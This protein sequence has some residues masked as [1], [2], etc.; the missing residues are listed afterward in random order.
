MSADRDQAEFLGK[1][2]GLGIRLL[3]LAVPVVVFFLALW[4]KRNHR[5]N[6]E[7]W[8]TVTGRIVHVKVLPIEK[9][10]RSMAILSYAYFAE[11]YEAGEYEQA[12]AKADEAYS[13]IKKLKDR[14]VLIRYNPAN[15]TISVLETR[16]VEQIAL[17]TPDS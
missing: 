8:P 14:E 12:F 6:A 17:S 2:V 7:S 10:T 16:I 13:F 11:S 5:K 15:P 4:V 9:S 3:I 1:F